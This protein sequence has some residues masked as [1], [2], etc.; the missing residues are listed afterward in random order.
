MRL[1]VGGVAVVA[2]GVFTPKV[3][4]TPA[5]ALSI[6][7][8][9]PSVAA[10]GTI[11]GG[12]FSYSYVLQDNL[13]THPLQGEDSLLESFAVTLTDS[14]G[15]SDTASLDIRI[16]DDVPTARN[17]SAAAAE[18]TPVVIDVLANDTRGADGVSNAT[19]VA[20]ATQAAKGVAVYNGNGTF[21]YT[22]APGAQ[23]NDSFTYTITDGDG[24][25]STALVTITL[26]DMPATVTPM[27]YAIQVQLLAYHTAVVMGTDVDQPRNLAKSVTVE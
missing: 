6:T 8:F 21:T 13:L 25:T 5:G 14:D 3:I 22:A 15:S 17:D 19:G 12:T 9:T 23:G 4:D 20:L 2:N 18:N 16:I 27:V 10:D 26:P 11:T 7:G 24:D 1:A